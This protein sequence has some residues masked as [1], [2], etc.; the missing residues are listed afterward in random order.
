M[1]ILNDVKS[2]LCL[3]NLGDRFRSNYMKLS[4]VIGL[5]LKMF[6]L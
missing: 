5:I 2:F 3:K 6:N 1:V 4:V